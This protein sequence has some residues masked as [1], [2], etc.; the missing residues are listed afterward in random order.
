MN[1]SFHPI[2]FLWSMTAVNLGYLSTDISGIDQASLFHL[3][4]VS[5]LFTVISFTPIVFFLT[6]VYE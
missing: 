2:Y 4:H 1:L 3:T 6:C 5:L